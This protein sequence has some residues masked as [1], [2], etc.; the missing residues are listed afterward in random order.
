MSIFVAGLAFPDGPLLAAAKLGILAAS[1]VSGVIGFVVLKVILAR[2][3]APQR[4]TNE[5]PGPLRRL[6]R[7]LPD[8]PRRGG[9]RPL[10]GRARPGRRAGARA[11]LA[12][13]GC[14]PASPGVALPAPGHGRGA[15][16]RDGSRRGRDLP[17]RLPR[18][19]R[20]PAAVRRP[21][22]DVP[23]ARAV[24]ERRLP[25]RLGPARG[26]PGVGSLA[27]VDRRGVGQLPG[28]PPAAR[29]Q[30]WQGI[31]PSDSWRRPPSSSPARSPT[32]AP[33]RA[34]SSS[35]T[36]PTCSRNRRL[37]RLP[38]FLPGGPGWSAQP[39]RAFTFATFALD[40]AVAGNDPSFHRAV[41]LGIHLAAALLVLALA[42]CRLPGAPPARLGA[43][44]GGLGGRAR[45][46]PALRRPPRPD[47][48][49]DLRRA[50]AHLARDPPLPASALLY[51]RWRIAR[52]GGRLR[53]A[54]LDPLRRR[55]PRR[56]ARHAVEGDRLH[57]AGGAAP[58]RGRALR[59]TV[60]AAAPRPRP[61]RGDHGP[62][63]GHPPPRGRGP[64]ALAG[65][66]R[67]SRP[68]CRP[69]WRASTT[70]SPSSP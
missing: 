47:A 18:G 56:A 6:R 37:D 11:R 65:E 16:D 7:V 10:P 36:P 53:M 42:L 66:P 1:A 67:S 45:G 58:P 62:H 32:R 28:S 31:S 34:P 8:A 38:D 54:V 35:T 69:T 64:P 40:R 61:L 30:R 51:V 39:N 20:V 59:R 25:G 49:G 33:S 46:R 43:G 50:A 9:P 21:A 26:G 5:R 52:E 2:A 27:G 55:P 29:V 23:R 57:P 60:E 3:P 44:A 19:D 14:W 48:G 41:N 24:G 12:A 70:C 17:L 68:A 4:V 13:T 22:A 15:G 63:P